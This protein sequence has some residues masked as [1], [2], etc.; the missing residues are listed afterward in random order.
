MNLPTI[1]TISRIFLVPFLV[2]V[3]LTKFAG[4]EIVALAIFLVAVLT[5]W[6]DGY[7]ARKRGEIT[8]LGMLLDPIA[9]K[10][11][12][13]AVFISLVEIGAASGWLVAVIISREFAVDGLRMVA[14]QRGIAI[15]ASRL[16]KYKMASQVVTIAVALLGERYLGGFIK[17]RDVL[18]WATM[19][20]AVVSGAEYFVRFWGLLRG[21]GAPPRDGERP[22]E[23]CRPGRR[24]CRVRPAI[25]CARSMLE[26]MPERSL[27]RIRYDRLIGE[28]PA[29]NSS[30]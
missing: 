16:G 26:G 27:R 17:V 5:D 1:L 3:I 30:A 2:M 23:G 24:P 6:L 11:L 28:D 29:W 19:V 12:V 15:A 20:I 8:V 10:I 7:L 25:S 21:G 4:K 9:D 13:S 18:L 14:I 22:R